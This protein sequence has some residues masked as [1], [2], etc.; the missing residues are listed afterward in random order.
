MLEYDISLSL[1]DSLHC[2]IGDEP[3]LMCTKVIFEIIMVTRV[4]KG[5]C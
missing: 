1:S 5:D 2:I 3:F 4:D